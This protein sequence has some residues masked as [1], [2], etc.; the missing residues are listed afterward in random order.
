MIAKEGVAIVKKVR[1]GPG[2]VARVLGRSDDDSAGEDEPPKTGDTVPGISFCIP[3]ATPVK[4]P[5]MAPSFSS[6]LLVEK[7]LNLRIVR[8]GG[9]TPFVE[10]L[11]C[12]QVK[13]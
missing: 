12:G 7:L 2:L 11:G 13:S 4:K 9:Q 10:R 6:Q 1:T 8:V 3:F 5:A